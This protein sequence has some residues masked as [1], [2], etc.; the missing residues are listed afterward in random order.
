MPV[1]RRQNFSTCINVI[2]KIFL[3]T[4]FKQDFVF[5]GAENH[6]NLLLRRFN[7]GISAWRNVFPITFL[8]V[9]T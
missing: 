3:N 9:K 2:R 1:C 5:D 6:N 4:L 7:G 8:H